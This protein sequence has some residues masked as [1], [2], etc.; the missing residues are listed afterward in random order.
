LKKK[1]KDISLKNIADTYLF[2]NKFA[3]TIPR[4]MQAIIMDI[5]TLGAMI[6]FFNEHKETISSKVHYLII[7]NM[8]ITIY[9]ICMFLEINE[10]I[11][12][13]HFKE[14]LEH[15][16]EYRHKIHQFRNKDFS[17]RQQNIDTSMGRSRDKTIPHLDIGLEFDS[18]YEYI[19]SNITFFDF[20]N[21]HLQQDIHIMQMLIRT[22]QNDS[23]KINDS[24]SILHKAVHHETKI[25][26]Y[27]YTN[28]LKH[29]KVNNERLLD[30]L[31]LGSD[32]LGSCI[33]LFKHTI[34]V[35]ESLKET[36]HILVTFMKWLS[37]SYNET[38]D[39]LQL[40]IKFSKPEASDHKLIK[41]IIDKVDN[42]IIEFS[43]VCRNNLHYNKQE[44]LKL[45]DIN[46]LYETFNKFINESIFLKKE[47]DKLINIKG[48]KWKLYGNKFLAW[49]QSNNVK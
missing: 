44:E 11:D 10:K 20:D 27:T 18:K 2:P 36:P 17:F 1:V 30:R 9:E 32:E 29:T 39:N 16:K 46:H 8:S 37:I 42:N 35:T 31:I 22:I 3:N 38:I 5:Y 21:N 23:F 26:P 7:K 15:I 41:A 6:D 12:D 14:F 43:T 28:I 34:V 45:L 40:F 25:F 24:Y 48:N 13:K 47:F 19:S 33:L 49:A 4:S